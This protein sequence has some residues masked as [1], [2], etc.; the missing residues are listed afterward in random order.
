V[1]IWETAYGATW[2]GAA[3][4]GPINCRRALL[5]KSPIMRIVTGADPAPPASLNMPSFYV[6]PAPCVMVICPADVTV[7]TTNSS[8]VVTYTVGSSNLCCPP[9]NTV[10]SCTPPSGSSFPMGSTSVGCTV[11]DGIGPSAS[12]SFFVSVVTGPIQGTTH[13]VRKGA[14]HRAPFT[15][16]ADAATN[17]QSAVNAATD[18][19]TVL[20]TNSVYLVSPQVTIIRAI[21]LR[22]VAPSIFTVLDGQN[23]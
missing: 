15:S 12:C 1:R 21:L 7:S 19:D 6:C 18:G 14:S 10:V 13:F 8:V 5:G 2:E 16:W 23:A 9:T 3:A 4:A 20:V 17:I 22:G 11:S